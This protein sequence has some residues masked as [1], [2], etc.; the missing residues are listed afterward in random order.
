MFFI[1]IG[2]FFLILSVQNRDSTPVWGL[3]VWRFCLGF[4]WRVGV[5]TLQ[6]YASSIKVSGD[7]GFERDR[8]YGLCLFSLGGQVVT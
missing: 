1:M 3:F 7:W 2:R 8:D 4:L 6:S 5:C